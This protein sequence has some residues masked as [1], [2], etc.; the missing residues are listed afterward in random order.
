M[1]ISSIYFLEGELSYES[2]LELFES[3]IHLA[4]AC[5]RR[6]AQVPFNLAHPTWVDDPELRGRAVDLLN[7]AIYK[8]FNAEKIEIPYAKQDLYIKAMPSQIN[9]AGNEDGDFN[10]QERSV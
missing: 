8:Q 6:L 5:R 9:P 2:V 7:D 10:Q 1:H 4:P 3:R